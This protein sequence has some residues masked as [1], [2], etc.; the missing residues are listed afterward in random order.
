MTFP[1]QP[2]DGLC[3][4]PRSLKINIIITIKFKSKEM[5]WLKFCLPSSYLERYFLLSLTHNF[6]WKS[7]LYIRF[8]GAEKDIILFRIWIGYPLWLM[9]RDF[10][11]WRNFFIWG[12]LYRSI[13]GLCDTSMRGIWYNS[14]GLVLDI[15]IWRVLDESIWILL[16]LVDDWI[17]NLYRSERLKIADDRI[18]NFYGS[19]GLQTWKCSISP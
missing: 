3:Q 16:D 14:V 17:I 5:E 7:Q 1:T 8:V 13:G 4:L 2:W 10:S 19:E 18:V 15:S 9:H 12:Q 11:I 6:L